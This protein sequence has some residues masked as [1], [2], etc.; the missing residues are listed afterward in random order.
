L[1]SN[2]RNARKHSQKQLRQIADSIV[3]LG[4][5]NPIIIDEKNNVIAE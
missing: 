1:K 3:A 4:W 5:T 2:R